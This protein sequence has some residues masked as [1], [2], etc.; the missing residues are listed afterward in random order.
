MKAVRIIIFAK[1]P[2]PGM[3]KTRLIPALGAEG[4][5]RLA[6]NMLAHT[7][8][9]ALEAAVGPVELCMSPA[10]DDAQWQGVALPAGI[11]LIAQGDGDLGARMA[12]A[13]QRGLTRNDAVLLIGTDCPELSVSQLRVA[14]GALND[15]DSVIHPTAD[16]GYALLGLTR[17]DEQLFSGI[18]W[19]LDGV[20][21]ATLCK[22][23][24]LG[25]S[26]HVGAILH[27]IDEPGDLVRLPNEWL[28]QLDRGSVAC[29]PAGLISHG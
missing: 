3:A 1:A 17:T 15:V 21:F 6:G 26:T 28:T 12:R 2:C 29:A 5:A 11:A 10:P 13:A 18:A 20:A 23:G 22:L 19:G 16:G 25:W 4:A 24:A 14:A 7:L 8:D 27:D 9:K